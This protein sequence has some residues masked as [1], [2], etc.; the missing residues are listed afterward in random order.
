MGQGRVRSSTRP[1]HLGSAQSTLVHR[2]GRRPA[3]CQSPQLAWVRHFLTAPDD[4]PLTPMGQSQSVLSRGVRGSVRWLQR[5]SQR[6]PVFCSVRESLPV[7]ARG[8]QPAWEPSSRATP[9][10]SRSPLF[11]ASTPARRR[12]ACVRTALPIRERIDLPPPDRRSR[13]VSLRATPHG[14]LP[15]GSRPASCSTRCRRVP[16]HDRSPRAPLCLRRTIAP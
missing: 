4:Q 11:A 14:R 6:W 7:G 10:L 13:P 2:P 5:C 16:R 3:A 12:N 15:K 9:S 8:R 1:R